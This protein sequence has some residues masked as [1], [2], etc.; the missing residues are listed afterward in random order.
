MICPKCGQQ[1]EDDLV[2]CS[3]CGIIFIK[4][5][6]AQHRLRREEGRGSRASR[7]KI[8]LLRLPRQ[9]SRRVLAAAVL[10]GLAWGLLASRLLSDR[11][12]ISPEPVR[13]SLRV[14]EKRTASILEAARA[15]ARSYGVTVNTADFSGHFKQGFKSLNF[16]NLLAAAAES[17]RELSTRLGNLKE[18]RGFQD[19]PFKCRI[20]GAWS[21]FAASPAQA[22]GIQE[23]WLMTRSFRP[24]G[25]GRAPS[26][27]IRWRKL[28]WAPRKGRWALF[29]RQQE[30]ELFAAYI[31][32]RL[33]KLAQDEDQAASRKILRS[34]RIP[35]SGLKRALLRAYRTRLR[36]EGALYRLEGLR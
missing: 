29:T 26:W 8:I 32:S 19:R 28:A 6:I 13:V 10:L 30:S 31:R 17:G 34:P 25:K 22:A 35:K 23:C 15:Q 11:G 16:E 2:S 3:N 27:T 36:R 24:G 9:F 4:W 14:I 1:A 21:F 5:M 33:G 18:D 7:L 20:D 12:P